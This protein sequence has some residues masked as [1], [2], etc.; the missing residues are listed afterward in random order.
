MSSWAI[1]TMRRVATDLRRFEDGRM[2]QDAADA[3]VLSLEIAYRELLV[4]EQLDGCSFDA[5]GAWLRELSDTEF[6]NSPE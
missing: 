4:Q 2:P 3:F 1:G 6:E 5:P